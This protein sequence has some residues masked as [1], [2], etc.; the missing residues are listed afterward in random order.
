MTSRTNEEAEPRVDGRRL[1]SQRSRQRI[2]DALTEAL[3]K[4]GAD[5]SPERV[6]AEAGVSI[7]TLFRHFKDVEGLTRDGWTELSFDQERHASYVSYFDRFAEAVFEGRAP[8]VP[9]EEGRKTLEVLLAAYESG[10]TQ[11]AVKLGN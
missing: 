2:L 8:D 9:G 5:A 3:S 11:K 1:R 4:P 7:S 6:A 10:K